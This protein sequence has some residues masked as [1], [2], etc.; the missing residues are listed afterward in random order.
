ML[1]GMARSMTA[2]SP[3][4]LALGIGDLAH[5]Y[6]PAF[7]QHASGTVNLGQR[8]SA[9]FSHAVRAGEVKQP[10][11]CF[12][13]KAS[14]LIAGSDAVAH[15]DTILRVRRAGESAQANHYIVCGMKNGEPDSPRIRLGTVLKSLKKFRRRGEKVIANARRYFES[16]NLFIMMGAF[17][18]RGQMRREVRDERQIFGIQA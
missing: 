1:L 14:S 3:N 17:A 5:L 6:E 18:E 9:Y 16:R 13:G 2:P 10:A 12:R 8:V 11:G 15:L 4:Q 7:L